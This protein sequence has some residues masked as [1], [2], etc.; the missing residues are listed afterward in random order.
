MKPSGFVGPQIFNVSSIVEKIGQRKRLEKRI[1]FFAGIRHHLTGGLIPRKAKKMGSCYV[2]SHHKLPKTVT[3][4]ASAH[5]S[6]PFS[7]MLHT[8]SGRPL[9]IPVFSVENLTR[10]SLCVH[11]FRNSP[12]V[13]DKVYQDYDY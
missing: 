3:A 4:L 11:L 1:D 8:I 12:P 5:T 9:V 10:C 2:I 6:N 7:C 13:Y